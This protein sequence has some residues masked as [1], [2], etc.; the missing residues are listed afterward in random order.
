MIIDNK[1]RLFGI[2]NIIDLLIVLI[3]LGAVGGVFVKGMKNNIGPVAQTRP[4]II[5]FESIHDVK[6]EQAEAI[7]ENETI[8]DEKGVVLGRL[9]AKE[10]LPRTDYIQTADGRWVLAEKPGLFMVRLTIEANAVVTEDSIKISGNDYPA[11]MT[12]AVKGKATKFFGIITS[13]TEK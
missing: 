11:G 13:I 9:V 3:V 8:R 6:Q 4:V 5:K 1:G 12:V 10:L 7:K 2:I